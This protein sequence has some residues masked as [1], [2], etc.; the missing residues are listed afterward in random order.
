[1]PWKKITRYALSLAILA[2]IFMRIDFIA[3]WQELKTA[4]P[5]T[6][7]WVTLLLLL[8]IS[9][10]NLRWHAI[11]NAGKHR[12]SFQK[13]VFTNVAGYFANIVIMPTIGGVLTKSGLVIKE[14][15]PKLFTLVATLLDRGMTLVALLV[16]SA[17]S[18]PFWYKTL[19]LASIIPVHFIYIAAIGIGIATLLIILFILKNERSR[20]I[21]IPTQILNGCAQLRVFVKDPALLVKTSLYSIISQILFIFCLYVLMRDTSFNGSYLDFIAL[22]PIIALLSALI[23]ITFGGWGLFIYAMNIVG[24]EPET[25]LLICAQLG[26]ATTIAPF[27]F[28]MLYALRYKVFRKN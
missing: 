11:L 13:S 5:L 20:K 24:M 14:G 18:F 1:M 8:Q 6:F 28:S 2:L 3:L 27:V 26:V 7:I 4:N 22:Q 16:L 19:P 23:P 10:L 17:I 25:S 21:F 12:I 15:F 9:V